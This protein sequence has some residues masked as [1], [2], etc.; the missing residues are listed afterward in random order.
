ML[1]TNYKHTCCPCFDKHG[2]RRKAFLYTYTSP[3]TERLK[4]SAL[5]SDEW[6]KFTEALLTINKRDYVI[7]IVMR[8]FRL[9][10]YEVRDIKLGELSIDAYGK[11]ELIGCK[12]VILQQPIR[13]IFEEVFT[14]L[15]K[16][17]NKDMTA[18]ITNRGCKV[19][20]SRLV[21]V[22]ARAAKKA[23]IKKVF[24]DLIRVV[25]DEE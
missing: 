13:I 4:K 23:G 5:T 8:L 14:K 3:S 16:I 24:P 20:R 12:H 22:F 21:H 10:S 6:N 11:L 9:R 18:F 2:Y 7:A 1:A 19:S 17:E 15:G 25:N